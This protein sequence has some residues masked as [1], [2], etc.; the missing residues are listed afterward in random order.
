M[1]VLSSDNVINGGMSEAFLNLQLRL[2]V[3]KLLHQR[4][5]KVHEVRTVGHGIMCWEHI[6]TCTWM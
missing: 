1:Y 4:S 5:L 3:L 6:L 2:R